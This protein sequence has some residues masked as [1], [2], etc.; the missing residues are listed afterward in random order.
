MRP[1]SLQTSSNS[2][3]DSG[4]RRPITARAASAARSHRAPSTPNSDSE[5]RVHASMRCLSAARSQW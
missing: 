3:R 5:R 4:P 2:E 1:A